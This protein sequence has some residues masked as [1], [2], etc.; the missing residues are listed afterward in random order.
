MSYPVYIPLY[1]GHTGPPRPSDAVALIVVLGMAGA[2]I[3]YAY[4]PTFQMKVTQENTYSANVNI[5]TKHYPIITRITNQNMA[6]LKKKGYRI[7]ETPDKNI[8]SSWHV[9][10]RLEMDDGSNGYMQKYTP[11]LAEKLIADCKE[12]NAHTEIIY[13]YDNEFGNEVQEKKKLYWHKC[14]V[15]ELK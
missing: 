2:A 14:Y 7:S 9:I 6:C 5:R 8:Y 1:F 13:K 11:L 10:T 4:K 15:N 12:C 3:H